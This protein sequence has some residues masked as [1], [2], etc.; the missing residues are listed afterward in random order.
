MATTIDSDAG[1]ENVTL[2]S[3]Q[4]QSPDMRHLIPVLVALMLA[5]LL[6]A[7]DQTVVATALPTIIREVGGENVTWVTT[8]YLLASTCMVPIIGKLSDLYG[9]R[10]FFLGGMVIFLLGSALSGTSQN[11][12]QLV[13]YRGFQGLGAGALMP[14]VLAFI[15]DIFPP[16]ER[17]KWQGL[18][19]GIFGLASIIGPLLGGAITDHWGWRWV[20][21]IN[22]PVGAV[23]FIAGILFL[24]QISTR[25]AH[26]I[27]YLGAAVLIIWAVA[28]LLGFSL[29][30]ETVG[31]TVWAWN[32]WQII[33]LFAIAVVGI[34]AFIIIERRQPEPILNPKLLLNDIFA[35]STLSMFL[36]GAGLFGAI[37]Y[38]VYFTSVVLGESSTNS[39]I[40]LT[41]LV[42]GFIVS[43]IIGG[44]LISRTGKYKM[45]ALA[46][47]AVTTLGM[48]MLSRMTTTTTNGEE[49]RDMI[50]TGLGMGVLTSLFTI[51]VQ[52]T[53]S[54]AMLGQV[55]AGLTFFRSL[56]GTIGVSVLGAIV[57]N[58]LT[59]KLDNSV[60]PAL[61]PYT[62]KSKLLSLNTLPNAI[63]Q[64]A[65]VN[66][67]GPQMLQ[68]LGLIFQQNVKESYASSITLAFAIGAGMMVLAFA[69]TFFL[70]EIPLRGKQHSN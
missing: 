36:L 16:A 59:R 32:S 52:N 37:T 57:T 26:T 13:L 48:F 38:L 42:M 31:N 3:A 28:L 21:Y 4:T 66:H 46:G 10:L 61:L 44:Q 19:S 58:T 43:S 56:G 45:L 51:V 65:A 7:L 9:R 5:M 24:P 47:F 64:K 62:D 18:F 34:V 17:G 1:S 53:F 2:S 70:R 50:I 35:I 63:N 41:P 12:T 60:P 8:S 29:G 15:G 54:N 27:D 11:M 25:I 67:L 40:I 69:I 55:T 20:F 14:V 23:T 30:G 68:Q 39:G 6:A 33:T 22:M 49:V